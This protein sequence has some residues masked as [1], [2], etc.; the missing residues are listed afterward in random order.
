MLP[1]EVCSVPE[2]KSRRKFV[3][4]RRVSAGLAVL[5]LLL[6][7]GVVFLG[8]AALRVLV[9]AIV[10]RLDL[11][12]RVE[13]RDVSLSWRGTL[14]VGYAA[15]FDPEGE[16]VASVSVRT[17][18]GL[19]G[20]L[21]GFVEQDITVDGWAS[22]EMAADGSTN[23]EEALGLG[24]GAE[25]QTDSKTEEKS[26]LG[27]LPFS[28][29]IVDGIDASVSRESSATFALAGLRGEVLAKGTKIDADL[30]ASIRMPAA[31]PTER[32]QIA[33]AA[34]HGSLE[35]SGSL[36]LDTLTG[37]AQ[38]R[39]TGLTEEAAGA[40]GQLSGDEA[41]RQASM[42]AA[43]GG[44][45]LNVDA[46]LRDGLPT[47]A[48]VVASSQ[49]IKA[50]LAVDQTDGAIVLARPG[51]FEI[52]TSAFLSNDAIRRMVFPA[53]G[54]G[55]DLAGRLEASL[56]QL[57]LPVASGS[58]DV[59]RMEVTASVGVGQ[60]RMR[61]PGPEGQPVLVRLNEFTA[62]AILDQGQPLRLIARAKA[63][64]EGQPDG[65]FDF[66]ATSDVVQLLETLGQDV[67]LSP[68]VLAGWVPSA[69]LTLD[70]V[71]IVAAKPWLAAV[72][73]IGLDV[74]RIVGPT[75]TANITWRAD[76]EDAV[77]IGLEI[78]AAHM[79]ASA[80][81]GWGADAIV[82]RAP[83]TLRVAQ[84][85]AL[86]SPWFPEGWA[87]ENG[88]GVTATLSRLRLPMDGLTP[89]LADASA[90]ARIEAAG[91]TLHLPDL[92]DVGV[93][94]LAL[95]V[96]AGEG[97]TVVELSAVPIVDNRP[98]ELSASL[99]TGGVGA[100][101]DPG[102]LPIVTGTVD[103]S[104]P[105]DVVAAYNVRLA[106][107]PLQTWIHEAM[108]PRVTARLQLV[109]PADSGLAAGV[110]TVSSERSELLVKG[111]SFSRQKFGLSEASLQATPGS[112]L[113]D[114]IAPML[115]MQGS[116]L[117]DSSPLLVDVGPFALVFGQ[118]GAIARGLE[119]TSVRLV[120][121]D[122][123]RI[124]GV[125][126]DQPGTDA[127]RRR[128]SIELAALSASL[129]SIGK[130]MSGGAGLQGEATVEARSP[131]RGPIAVVR[132][133]AVS[134]PDGMLSMGVNVDE[135]DTPLVASLAGLA[136]DAAQAVV[137]SLGHTARF[138]V[139]ATVRA[140]PLGERPWS[141][142]GASA[143]IDSTNL[144][145]TTPIVVEF[146]RD[147]IS[148]TQ[149]ASVTWKPDAQWIKQAI[150]A[151]VTS[152]E[153]FVITLARI[154][155]GNPLQGETGL[156]APEAVFIDVGVKGKG[157]MIAIEDRP[158]IELETLDA[159][160]RRIALSSYSI[161]ANAA[162]AGGGTLEL[163]G[164]LSDLTNAQGEVDLAN[165]VARGTL[166]GDDVPVSIADAMSN[167]DGLLADSLGPVVD[168]D[169]EVSQGKLVPGQP[170][171]ADLRF[172]VRGPRADVSGYGRL[173][174]H[175][176]SMPESQTI[177]T[178][179]EVRPE[180][181]ER[182]SEL[183]PE[184]LLVE[185]RPEDGPAV[186]QTDG[187]KIPT[188]GDWSKGQGTATIALG[189]ARFQTTSLLA[190]VLRATGQRQQG[191]V[192]Q[193]IDPIR[194]SMVDGVITYEPFKL[195]LGDLTIESEGTVN[196]VANEMNVL[197]WLPMAA[198]SDEA[199][200]SFNTGLGSL[201][202]RTIPGF[203][204]TTTVPWRVSGPLDGP[205]IRPAPQVLIQRR[206]DQLLGPLLRPGQTVQDILSIPRKREDAPKQGG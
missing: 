180:I 54:V 16:H 35:L 66:D 206:G 87:M 143:T 133:R 73:R 103:L 188:N 134:G 156:L 51:A 120:A 83:A 142:I 15:V 91:A 163:N 56:E 8:P 128:T 110:L 164:L 182:F 160:V 93:R 49:T 152:L 26:E 30:A 96:T 185:K 194:V 186:I 116:R 76:G 165:A 68:M 95:D 33:D 74:P 114:S 40:L 21:D 183:I 64:V 138:D 153:P 122:S 29:I 43:R 3:W 34:V 24:R 47:E 109:E 72:E 118:E 6:F 89:R 195:P 77:A 178:L 125:P 71:P 13:V 130:V 69:T 127:E 12:G 63:G 159:R 171:A 105:A 184:L 44:L 25:A 65:T 78:D 148:L 179:R 80:S 201:V 173:E 20:L 121:Q 36:A 38:A 104:V 190:S 181:A 149:P 61:V 144:Q 166:K 112:G 187:V 101:L 108:G 141:L 102:Q 2:P 31:R 137:G 45:I 198:L 41:I 202:G 55:V 100:L 86:A 60:T 176:I 177:L 151:E 70:A 158:N 111:L 92:P 132:A 57:R 168:L 46:A 19:L 52:E 22:I 81:A 205:S 50:E 9:P 200:G 145:T 97:A 37:K 67:Q 161:T 23:I 189:T 84:P 59:S 140:T 157:A 115:G 172:S 146:S 136:E 53:E 42:V 129:S 82:L 203:G 197:V 196:L 192:G 99:R 170:P 147:S 28:R 75:L 85:D 62:R 169:A 88:Q 10:G 162:A 17:G 106:D 204:A 155:L 119:A 150:G 167:T 58:V 175:V 18:G 79:Q 39:I 27:R 126:L 48:I 90:V 154:D 4:F 123:I 191:R 174:D 32:H 14:S 131:D 1:V 135:L 94:T 117:V 199:A 98:A 124:D 193:R 5:V 139:S 7:L 107:R 113:W 11:P